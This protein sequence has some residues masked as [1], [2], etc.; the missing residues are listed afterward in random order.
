MKVKRLVSLVLLSGVPFLAGVFVGQ[1]SIPAAF[2][3]SPQ[4]RGNT[5]E[6]TIPREW[7]TV[8]AY[9][10]GMGGI[11]MVFEGSDGTIRIVDLSPV[12][13]GEGPAKIE[14]SLAR[15]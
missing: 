5:T 9:H 12:F 8:K 7:G 14:L 6:A 15:H 3:Q 13:T 4:T 2:A 1:V 10:A 11:G